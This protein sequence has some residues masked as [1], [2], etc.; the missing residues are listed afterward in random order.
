M[1]L[2]GIARLLRCRT[3]CRDNITHAERHPLTELQLD[4]IVRLDTDCHGRITQLRPQNRSDRRV[5]SWQ[6]GCGQLLGLTS[7]TRA[8]VDAAAIK[9]RP[10][11]VFF[12]RSNPLDWAGEEAVVVGVLMVILKDNQSPLLTRRG[13]GS[14]ANLYDRLLTL[15][16]VRWS[17]AC[18]SLSR[19]S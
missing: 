12:W 10:G 7:A 11:C 13:V 2:K 9:L 17:R 18:L 4:V 3:V 16:E 8:A 19:L 1:C 5:H 6:R 15:A 14:T